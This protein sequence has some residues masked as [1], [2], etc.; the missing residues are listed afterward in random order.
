VLVFIVGWALV[1]FPLTVVGAMRGRAAAAKYDPPCKPN[2]VPREIPAIPVY[3]TAPVQ[4]R[5][6]MTCRIVSA[7]CTV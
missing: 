2:R 7:L 3:R 6:W 4:V 1:T 5:E